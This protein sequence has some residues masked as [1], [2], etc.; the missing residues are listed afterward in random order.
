[1]GNFQYTF[2]SEGTD[3]LIKLNFTNQLVEVYM[4]PYGRSSS[5]TPDYEFPFAS[6]GNDAIFAS[7]IK[8]FVEQAVAH[9]IVFLAKHYSTGAPFPEKDRLFFFSTNCSYSKTKEKPNL[10]IGIGFLVAGILVFAYFFSPLIRGGSSTE[11]EPITMDTLRLPAFICLLCFSFFVILTRMYFTRVKTKGFNVLGTENGL[12][13]YENDK[14]ASYTWD[15]FTGKQ[16]HLK[17]EKTFILEL[18][19]VKSVYNKYGSNKTNKQLTFAGVSNFEFYLSVIL[20]RI[21]KK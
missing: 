12:I 4:D 20:S 13:T 6:I 1:M 9:E 17:D 21:N 14:M 19:E 7:K 8:P 18:K 11:S 10:K 5:S 16:E 15:S 2:Q 3:N